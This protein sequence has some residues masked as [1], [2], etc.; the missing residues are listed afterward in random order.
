MTTTSLCSAQDSLG[1]SRRKVKASDQEVVF[2]VNRKKPVSL[3]SEMASHSARP[4]KSEKQPANGND[5]LGRS[6]PKPK[7]RNDAVIDDSQYPIFHSRPTNEHALKTSAVNKKKRR[8]KL[9]K[10]K[11]ESPVAEDARKRL[12]TGIAPLPLSKTSERQVV[13][14]PLPISVLESASSTKA[15]PVYVPP[16]SEVPVAARVLER[17]TNESTQR[18]FEPKLIFYR[19]QQNGSQAAATNTPRTVIENAVTRNATPSPQ[20]QRPS[21]VLLSRSSGNS[22]IIR[23]REVSTATQQENIF[24]ARMESLARRQQERHHVVSGQSAADVQNTEDVREA[25]KVREHLKSRAEASTRIS[26]FANMPKYTERGII[27]QTR[28][29][30]S[31]GAVDL[32]EPGPSFEHEFSGVESRPVPKAAEQND[33]V[34]LST[35]AAAI[36]TRN[37]QPGTSQRI[38]T[39]KAKAKA[40]STDGPVY[41]NFTD[42]PTRIS[43]GDQE[44]NIWNE[45]Q[46]VESE[47]I[48]TGTPGTP[49]YGNAAS[50]VN[51]SELWVNEQSRYNFA[52]AGTAELGEISDEDLA[53]ITESSN[54]QPETGG[55]RKGT[56]RQ[57]P[58]QDGWRAS[59]HR[60]WQEE[61]AEDDAKENETDDDEI[62]DVDKEFDFEDE[63][64]EDEKSVEQQRIE[65]RGD[66]HQSISLVPALR[67]LTYIDNDDN[68]YIPE[69]DEQ[70]LYLVGFND[71]YNNPVSFGGVRTD[72]SG[73][74][75]YP[76]C[77]LW[78]SPDLCHQPLYF[79]DANL[80]RFGARLPVL[81]PAI[82]GLHFFSSTIRLPYKMALDPTWECQYVAGYGRPGNRYCYQRERLNWNL[83]AGSFQALLITGLVFALP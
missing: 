30:D 40:K 32:P 13:H 57:V 68:T 51:P 23:S 18:Q 8:K 65:Y 79:E 60:K 63:S 25:N 46:K 28:K 76:K 56:R 59:Y 36:A 62:D 61:Q 70:R 73:Q 75:A 74:L 83:K 69:T 49:K 44:P 19:Q 21:E 33:R 16:A 31:N 38:S 17:P 81:Q 1:T 27:N 5:F 22:D 66:L 77:A 26:A 15:E 82:S 39:A 47:P 14:S 50:G 45:V 80:E 72:L 3:L 43:F 71:F 7:K 67:A 48:G 54:V 34:G 29:P 4:K 9:R 55:L 42:G 53:G 11:R 6:T 58:G 64:E 20:V 41:A 35:L 37:S 12:A 24:Q 10:P 2:P 78:K 52:K